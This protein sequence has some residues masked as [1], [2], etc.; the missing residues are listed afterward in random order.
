M[1][2][3]IIGGGSWGVTLANIL[4]CNGHNVLIYERSVAKQD[5]INLEHVNPHFKDYH[6]DESIKATKTLEEAVNFSSII[7]LAIPSKAFREVLK[8]IGEIITS[9]KLFINVAKGIEPD[10]LYTISQVVYDSLDNKYIEGFVTL[11]GPSLAK[12]VMDKKIT[13]VVAASKVEE[14]AKLV[15][16][17]FSNQEYFR[18]Y[19]STDLL[20]VEVN[21]SVKNAIAL[22]AGIV[23]GLNL[24]EN[25]R[26]ALI[27]RGLEE[28]KKINN[29]YGGSVNSLFGLSGV[30]DLIVTSVSPKSRNFQ[31]GL[32]VAKGLKISDIEKESIEIV[33]GPRTIISCHQIALKYNLELPIIETC[34]QVLFEDVNLKSSIDNLMKRNLKNE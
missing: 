28:L 6:I 33:E 30:G 3:S 27:C 5:I 8:N 25:A 10:T 26:A 18:V 32:K 29:A 2:I 1:K 14:D 7:V 21:G 20:G 24:G 11:S 9:P 13:L 4:A 34:Y 12:D 22:I 15:Q 17:L 16:T 23:D 31:A 19:T